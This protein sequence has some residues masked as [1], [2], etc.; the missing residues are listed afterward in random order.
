MSV[1]GGDL[2]AEAG[3]GIR[4][5]YRSDGPTD[6]PAVLLI[7]GL[8]LD[9]TSWPPS[10]VDGLLGRGLRVLR[11][12]NR[13]AG[14]STRATT[15]A[16]TPWQ[17]LR[18]V[19]PAGA[20]TLEDMAADHV[21]LLDALGIRR[22]HL[23][24]MSLGGMIAQTIAAAHPDRVLSLTSIFSTTGARSVGQ[25]AR[26]TLV[27]M[28][29]PGAATGP[30]FARR[31]VG[32]LGHIGS[33][34]YPVDVARETRW[35]VDAWERGAGEQRATGMAR[36][37]GAINA[38]GD[39]TQALARITAPTL[40]LH[41]DRDLMVAPSGGRATAAAV[42]GARHVT[43]PGMRHH[44]P[45]SLAPELLALIGDHIRDAGPAHPSPAPSSTPS[46]TPRTDS[47]P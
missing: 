28:V 30:D 23:V 35:A 3:H 37:I 36:Q 9:L 7:A 39:R 45:E 29:R 34:R 16:P 40:V 18:G 15:P 26:S 38:S 1:E 13:D 44:L 41:G 4:I 32:M 12:D 11:T 33:T 27:R 22:V 24:G 8:G 14:R 46:A 21:G 25:P 5:C 17:Q 47:T 6:A 2:F 43:I 10:L 31:H 19:A 42:R 20:Y